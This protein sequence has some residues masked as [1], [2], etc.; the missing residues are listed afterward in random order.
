MPASRWASRS[1]AGP[2]LLST[3]SM[4]A[5]LQ[6]HG[7]L[8][9]L[10]SNNPAR[11]PGH[12][13]ALGHTG[14]GLRPCSFLQE[15]PEAEVPDV[16]YSQRCFQAPLL[17]LRT[18]GRGTGELQSPRGRQEGLGTTPASLRVHVFSSEGAVCCRLNLSVGPGAAAPR[19]LRARLPHRDPSKGCARLH[20]T[21][22]APNWRHRLKPKAQQILPDSFSSRL[23]DYREETELLLL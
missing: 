11:Q 15:A 16:F 10:A 12:A 13:G 21:A 8:S 2:E 5:P 14:W 1:R 7:L 6:L 18:G 4:G 22:R 20:H 9:R 19:C 23:S 17:R 3:T